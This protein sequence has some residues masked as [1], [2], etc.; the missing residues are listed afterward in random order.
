[1]QRRP[2]SGTIQALEEMQDVSGRC[3]WN[4]RME[5]N[6]KSEPA[7]LIRNET[8]LLLSEALL[9]LSTMVSTNPA[10]QGSLP[11]FVSG[12]SFEGKEFYGINSLSS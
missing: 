5:F 6:L 8:V 3:W 1:M 2:S 7:F 10:F 9:P 11:F 12:K 4:Y